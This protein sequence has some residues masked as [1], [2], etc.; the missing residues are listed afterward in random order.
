MLSIL[1]MI[2]VVLILLAPGR[3][4]ATEPQP[5]QP[6]PPPPLAGP[7]WQL[8]DLQGETVVPGQT[9]PYLLFTAAGELVGFGGCNYF[10]GRYHTG[11]DGK[12]VVSA[13]RAA[14]DK[15]EETSH[16]ETTL[17]TSLVLA[18]AFQVQSGEL[19][20][21]RDGGI[22]LRLASAP[23]IDS[24]PLLKEGAK[25]KA[26]KARAKKAKGKKGKKKGAKSQKNGKPK[27]AGDKSAPKPKS[28]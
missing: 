11:E 13:L 16:Q 23:E 1:R 9:A 25:L 4:W 14:R 8:L 17:L 7:V 6:P 22:L 27:T 26:K 21:V 18:N 24:A 15:C 19:T 5:P 12:I 28:R 2:L 3:P 10:L 20:L